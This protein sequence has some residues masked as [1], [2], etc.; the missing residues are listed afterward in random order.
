MFELVYI[1]SDG[2]I[3]KYENENYELRV[4]SPTKYKGVLRP[5]QFLFTPKNK[6]VPDI[7][8]KDKKIKIIEARSSDV[9]DMKNNM[10]MLEEIEKELIERYD[11]M[12]NF[13]VFVD[14]NDVNKQ[15]QKIEDE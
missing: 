11:E 4:V 2:D 15:Y 9:E 13:S 10:V 8:F 1:T 6:I 12:S 5:C 3:K 7:K 14:A